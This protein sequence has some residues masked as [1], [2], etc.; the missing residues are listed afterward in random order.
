MLSLFPA[1][2]YFL[3][4]LFL[5][6]ALILDSGLPVRDSGKEDDDTRDNIRFVA[7]CIISVISIIVL[8]IGAMAT[9][10]TGSWTFARYAWLL[11]LLLAV[12]IMTIFQFVL[13]PAVLILKDKAKKRSKRA[14]EEYSLLDKAE[15]ERLDVRKKRVEEIETA[16]K[17]KKQ[18]AIYDE[19]I[20]KL[21]ARYEKARAEFNRGEDFKL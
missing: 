3:A 7:W 19:E 4:Y 1:G 11:Y 13:Y 10:S 18:L 15:L 9:E 8:V 20:A 17:R 14:K 2:I 21:D 6:I 5:F 12:I 16:V